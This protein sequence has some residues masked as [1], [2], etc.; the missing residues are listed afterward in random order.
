MDDDP[1]TVAEFEKRFAAEATCRI[2]LAQVRWP[3]GLHCPHRDGPPAWP[4]RTV[5][6]QCAAGGRQTSV[7]AGTLFQDTRAPLT[8]W[9]RAMWYVT[10]SKPGTSAL[11]LQQVWGLGSDR[12]AWA[13][14]HK[15]RRAM[16]RIDCPARWKSTRVVWAGSGTPRDGRPRPRP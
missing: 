2:Y 10:S 3:D 7:T 5:L 16:V 1:R 11:A 12:T 4:V 9:F 6:W 13:W 15:L 8:T 14:L